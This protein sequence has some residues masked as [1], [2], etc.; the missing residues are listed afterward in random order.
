[1]SAARLVA[2]VVLGLAAGL[3]AAQSPLLLGVVAGSENDTLLL[4]YRGDAGRWTELTSQAPAQARDLALA[5]AEDFCAGQGEP[6]HRGAAE[7]GRAL[8]NAPGS[9]DRWYGATS[10][11]QAVERRALH[12]QLQK[13]GCR[14]GWGL[15]LDEPV[16]GGRGLVVLANAPADV[17]YFAMDGTA[18]DLADPY[19]EPATPAQQHA[20]V[21]TFLASEG[22]GKDKAVAL[23][24][25]RSIWQKRLTLGR[26][27]SLV[28]IAALRSLRAAAQDEY[29]CSVPMMVATTLFRTGSSGPPQRL[30]SDAFVQRCSVDGEP[31]P[32]HEPLAMVR[33][34]DEAALLK[35]AT[36]HGAVRFSLQRLQANTLAPAGAPVIEGDQIR[37]N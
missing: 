22:A 33:S 21:G 8:F 31:M 18:Q 6:V 14:C 12:G 5:P 10:A 11:G 24:P 36:G 16:R 34:G 17:R 20:A 13:T 7:F 25:W 32:T 27:E 4:L 2:A 9:L 26:G 1:M 29:A 35:I 3:A 15:R 23:Q 19:W 37:C 28:E 30:D